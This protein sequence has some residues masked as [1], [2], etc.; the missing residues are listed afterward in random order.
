MRQA[1][2]RQGRVIQQQSTLPMLAESDVI[3]AGAGRQVRGFAGPG[4]NSGVGSPRRIP[5][6]KAATIAGG[7][8]ARVIPRSPNRPVR[9]TAGGAA[10][11]ATCGN[12]A[13]AHGVEFAW[14]LSF[15]SN[16]QVAVTC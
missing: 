14:V 1:I 16:E 4:R 2:I 6:W 5:T 3:V 11:Y 12:S 13:Q 9:V 15:Q 10:G 7:S 8:T